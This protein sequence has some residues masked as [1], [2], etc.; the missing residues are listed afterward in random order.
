MCE[1]EYDGRWKVGAGRDNEC[2]RLKLGAHTMVLVHLLCHFCCD[3]FIAELLSHLPVV[4]PPF[5]F[6]LQRFRRCNIGAVGRSGGRSAK[7]RV[8]SFA[9][10]VCW[11]CTNNL[12]VCWHSPRCCTY[13]PV[14]LPAVCDTVSHFVLS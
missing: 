7:V 14:L 5:P 11:V 10:C 12:P 8:Q 3:A 2:S 9:G 1:Y 13:D 6:S 4:I